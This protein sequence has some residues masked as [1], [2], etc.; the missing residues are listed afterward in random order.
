[1]PD[2]NMRNNLLLCEL[3]DIN[4][5]FVLPNGNPVT[6]LSDINLSIFR[7]EIV[8]LLGPSGCGKS[9]LLRILTGLI[10]PTTGQVL[11]HGIPLK[12]VNPGVSIVFQN[13]VLYPWMTVL[14]N[15]EIVLKAKGIPR[16]EIKQFADKAL[17]DVGLTGY[18]E[19][20][21]RE[22]SGGMKQRV[23]I[24]RALV[25][26]PEILCM[27][28]PFSQV[29]AL[30]AETLRAEVLDI[31][32]CAEK[33]PTTVFMVS[34]DIKEVV[35]MADRIVI[36]GSNPG[37]IRSI[38]QNSLPR[39]RNYRSAEF[40][41]LVD[42]IHRIITS[43]IIPD[44][45]I[46]VAPVT[47][48]T[49]FVLEP[50]PDASVNEIIGLLEVL[51]AHQGERDI[52]HLA[53]EIHKEFG[54]LINIAKAAELLDFVDTPKQKILLTE[55]GKR[56]VESDT[57]DR[58]RLWKEQLYKLTIY[59]RILDMLKNAPKGRLER[60]HVEEELV[61]HLPQE[62]PL[63]MFNILTSWARYGELFAYSED[64]GYITFE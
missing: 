14:E 49:E 36:M 58:K 15:V 29:D 16:S 59:N 30:T 12:D 64:T 57:K 20:Y 43:A 21:P 2:L 33:N 51:N 55:L 28:E 62:D 24:A 10:H 63:K 23:G 3:K 5:S 6:V 7:E 18:E 9:T 34:H 39:P 4:H 60:N 8:A 32:S 42:R 50:M 26:E 52:F 53:I 31:W 45:E 27:D 54:H 41:S 1:M 44:E 35:Y 25:V 47:D 46:P 13:F 61:L 38:L 56:F 11:S 37:C 22:L 19:A 48:S 40:L 17:H